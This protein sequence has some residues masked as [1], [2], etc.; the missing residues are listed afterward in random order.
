MIFEADSTTERKIQNACSRLSSFVI[1]K[2]VLFSLSQLIYKCLS[3]TLIL[4]YVV[5]TH[6]GNI[7]A[8]IHVDFCYFTIFKDYLTGLPRSLSRLLYYLFQGRV[9]V[10]SHS[11]FIIGIEVELVL[12]TF[13]RTL[14]F[15]PYC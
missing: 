3:I 14:V 11:S 10:S 2:Q 5:T 8:N 15:Y 13:K 4:T 9:I 12:S 7:I 1:V 6:G